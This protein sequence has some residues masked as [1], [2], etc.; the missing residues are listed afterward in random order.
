[1]STAKRVNNLLYDLGIEADDDPERLVRVLSKLKKAELVDFLALSLARIAEL[2]VRAVGGLLDHDAT[3]QRH[4]NARRKGGFA[5][6]ANDR[7]RWARLEKRYNEIRP[8]AKTKRE[9][10]VRLM[11]QEE[12]EGRTVKLD[13]LTR[14]FKDKPKM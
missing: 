4:K 1:M 3:R 9:A 7:A 11:N 5:K 8:H 12:E 13:T 14:H 6:N 10:C 2:E